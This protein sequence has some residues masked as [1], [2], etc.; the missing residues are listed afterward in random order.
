MTTGTAVTS[1]FM[2]TNTPAMPIPMITKTG[3]VSR[4]R[5]TKDF[6]L[7]LMARVCRTQP[8]RAA[9]PTGRSPSGRLGGLLSGLGRGL[10]R[11]VTR[12][13]GALEPHHLSHDLFGLA[14]FEGPRLERR[15]YQ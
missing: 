9:R 8:R 5:S 3:T 6:F 14:L 12:T 11:R 1:T 13:R 15:E 10:G 7:S 4:A 2:A